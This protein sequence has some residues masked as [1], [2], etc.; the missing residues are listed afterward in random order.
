VQRGVFQ[1]VYEGAS[2]II[3]LLPHPVILHRYVESIQ[4]LD[5]LISSPSS[6]KL[7]SLNQKTDPNSGA[8]EKP[9]LPSK[10]QSS[11]IENRGTSLSES[12]IQ[13]IQDLD[14]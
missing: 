8:Q 6:H 14:I 9:L 5:P 10:S 2:L 11:S 7:G 13:A 12:A 4:S 1:D 3:S